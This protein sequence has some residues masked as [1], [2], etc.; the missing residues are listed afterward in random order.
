M[1]KRL[2]Y[3]SFTFLTLLLLMCVAM[4][5]IQIPAIAGPL[6]K[7]TDAFHVEDLYIYWTRDVVAEDATNAQSE[8][9]LVDV[10][11]IETRGELAALLNSIAD[12][13]PRALAL[14]LIFAPLSMAD[15]AQD[16]QL[17]RALERFPQLIL[18]S[19][20]HT[21]LQGAHRE[22]SF[23]VD[24]LSNAVEGESW[25]SGSVVRTFSP[26]IK[27]NN[28][29]SFAYCIAEALHLNVTPT[30][31]Q[32]D[33][34]YLPSSVFT[35][36]PAKEQMNTSFLR[37]KVIIVGDSK[38]LR[39]YHNVPLLT[40]ANGRMPGMMIHLASVLT[41]ASKHPINHMPAW[42]NILL[43]AVLL[44]VLCLLFCMYN[45]DWV[46]SNWYQAGISLVFSIILMALG[47]YIFAFRHY[48]ISMIYFL[49]G[50][51]FAS[52]AKDLVDGV[53][54][55]KETLTNKRIIFFKKG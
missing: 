21:D 48:T 39:D 49:M 9:V 5:C 53:T 55:I 16:H 31:E 3:T 41:M 24:S 13:Q 37:D 36:T 23:F 15:S 51:P 52:F 20:C 26:I 44:W 22:H 29:P 27:E 17:L 40:N 28:R 50:C 32:Q 7:L 12:A 30:T 38:D 19:H 2:C 42:L 1:K 34:C 11:G 10:S 35:W 33:I 54:Q 14:D 45:T 6:D 47:A 18:A 46:M 8:L 25:L 43:Q 4:L